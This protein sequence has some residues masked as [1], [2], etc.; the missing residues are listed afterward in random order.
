[1]IAEQCFVAGQKR[2]ALPQTS[3]HPVEMG[4][5]HAK[6]SGGLSLRY[7]TVLFRFGHIALRATVPERYIPNG[8]LLKKKMSS[9]SETLARLMK[10]RNLT[11]AQLADATGISQAAISRYLKG[12]TPKTSELVKLAK[13]FGVAGD[14]L[15]YGALK[16]IDL[17]Q[18]SYVSDWAQRALGKMEKSGDVGFDM[19]AEAISYSISKLIEESQQMTRS[20]KALD[21]IVSDLIQRPKSEHPGKSNNADN[22][23]RS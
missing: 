18:S 21:G 15:M 16:V 17:D 19:Q 4:L 5:A 1:L 13:Q 12:R 10:E 14:Y 7:H 9:F 2:T 20:L 8:I 6:P 11:Q 3:Q 22:K 23:G